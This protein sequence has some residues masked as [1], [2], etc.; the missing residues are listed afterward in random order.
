M[1]ILT[2]F[3]YDYWAQFGLF[4]S[5]GKLPLIKISSPN[6]VNK[7]YRIRINV[8]ISPILWLICLLD[9]P[10]MWI[11]TQIPNKNGVRIIH[12]HCTAHM[13]ANDGL[14]VIWRTNEIQLIPNRIITHIFAKLSKYVSWYGAR[15]FAQTKALVGEVTK[16]SQYLLDSFAPRNQCHSPHLDQLIISLMRCMSGGFYYYYSSLLLS[17]SEHM[18][19]HRFIALRMISVLS[20]SSLVITVHIASNNKLWFLFSFDSLLSSLVIMPPGQD[21]A[22]L[23]TWTF[24]FILISLNVWRFSLTE[25]LNWNKW[26]RDLLLIAVNFL[27]W[28]LPDTFLAKQKSV[29]NNIFI[30]ITPAHRYS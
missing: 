5:N 3:L 4:S 8:A 15:L 19:I 7:I 13:L 28:L 24:F 1:K 10:R 29:F 30:S 25:G 22:K 18:D 16:S 12:A 2:Y 26:E 20:P 14:R 27:N 21:I 11:R 9:S 6:E 23:F 17:D